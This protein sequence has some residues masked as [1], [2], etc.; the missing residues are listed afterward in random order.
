MKAVILAAG[1]GSRLAPLTNDRPKSLVEVGGKSFLFRQ[2]E[3]L[4]AA[5]IPSQD[6]IVVGGYKID[7]LRDALTRGGFAC[8][9]LFND[10]FSDWNNFYSLL[11]ARE[12]LGG[13]DFLQLD[14][15]TILDGKLLPKIL[16]AT[17]DALVA[18]DCRDELDDETM[19][20][21][22]AG[23][24]VRAISKKLDPARCAG[25]YI[26]VTRLAASAAAKIFED[27]TRFPAE[28]L[29]HEYYEHAYHR[30]TGS[31]VV[32]FGIVDVHDCTVLEID[33]VE[34]LRRAEALLGHG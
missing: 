24:R 27:L 23:D 11:V 4:A 13:S 1:V 9:I 8:P 17:G 16:A 19:K 18:V 25:E 12:A 33:T 28:N 22:L 26:G 29:T 5:G 20:V 21:E 3:L 32:P 7:F 10:H 2:L 34:D 30:L 31:G 6:V 14:G 15:D